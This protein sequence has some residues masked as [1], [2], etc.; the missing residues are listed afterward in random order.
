MKKKYTLF[1]LAIILLVTL[2]FAGSILLYLK[3]KTTARG[4][5]VQS[6]I[7]DDLNTFTWPDSIKE[8]G[9]VTQFLPWYKRQPWDIYN[10]DIAFYGEIYD[11]EGNLLAAS[12]N[13][14]G[15]STD[16]HP[17][18]GKLR[19][20]LVDVYN[21]EKELMDNEYVFLNYDRN[22]RVD[23]KATRC[24]RFVTIVHSD[25]KVYLIYYA[26][27]WTSVK[28][29]FLGGEIFAFLFIWVL[30]VPIIVGATCLLYRQQQ[31]FDNRSRTIAHGIA[32]ELKTPLA[33]VKTSV[34]NWQSVSP[35]DREEYSE[36]M[37]NEI[38]H[39]SSMVTEMLELSKIEAG[40]RKLQ[41]EDVDL[42]V[43]THVVCRQ[44]KQLIDERH[45]DLSIN[46]DK[47]SDEYLVNADL[48]LMKI[49][50]GNYISN[51]VKFAEKN[52]EI[53]IAFCGKKIEYTVM[54][55]GHSMSKEECSRVWDN[56]YKV[57]KARTKRMDS[58]GLGLAVTKN[59]FIAHKAEYGCSCKDNLVKFWFKMK[60]VEKKNE[61]QI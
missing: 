54:N 14:P 8:Y 30:F 21:K 61:S 32:H 2:G 56:F 28:K 5:T 9:E 52:I 25:Y 55:D 23:S 22:S 37:I 51:A 41:P 6:V 12:E 48:E 3:E 26:D 42:L 7:N 45:L 57:D 24:W 29:E 10:Y 4:Q 33:V 35:E 16:N 18:I 13:A 50:L 1:A 38:D 46:T 19:E 20:E 53:T 58:T 44:Y 39:M 15:Y 49:A 59:I 47:S 17:T 11:S 31:A 40:Q 34:E 43:L 27:T 36:N 60:R